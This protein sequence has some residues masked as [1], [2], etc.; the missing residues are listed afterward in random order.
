MSFLSSSPDK[1]M[2]LKVTGFALRKT[3]QVS[4]NS[5]LVLVGYAFGGTSNSQNEIKLHMS[6]HTQQLQLTS[7]A[8]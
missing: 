8:L 2:A 1:D 5:L 7:E 6:I 3:Q 4:V